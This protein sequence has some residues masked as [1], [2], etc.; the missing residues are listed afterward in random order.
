MGKRIHHMGMVVEREK[1]DDFHKRAPD[2]DPRQHEALMRRM[3]IT[4]EE[5]AAWHK[6]HLTL[7]ELRAQALKP[8]DPFIIGIAFSEYCIQQGWMVQRG[9]DYFAT[10]EGV[11]E[12]RSRFDI[13]L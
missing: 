10:K 7:G 11:G 3:G 13:G 6:A 8:I 1:H 5:D 9:K 12:L 4:P 2:L